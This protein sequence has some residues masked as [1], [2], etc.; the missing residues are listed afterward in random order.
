LLLAA[1]HATENPDWRKLP[2][3]IFIH[4]SGGIARGTMPGF[5]RRH[6]AMVAFHESRYHIGNPEKY[7]HLSWY[8]DTRLDRGME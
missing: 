1:L 5:H 6:P 4:G 7:Q 2:I 3:L 8:C